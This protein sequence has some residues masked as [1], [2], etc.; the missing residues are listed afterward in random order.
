M[1]KFLAVLSVSL[2][3]SYM[4]NAQ[5]RFFAGKFP[6]TGKFIGSESLK[7]E[8]L[9]MSSFVTQNNDTLHVLSNHRLPAPYEF[10]KEYEF[11]IANNVPK[12][13]WQIN[14]IAEFCLNV[15]IK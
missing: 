15:K 9:V 7:G 10:D 2:C 11:S 8:S 14:K 13:I 4:S 3:M 12:K 6:C 5:Q 1:K